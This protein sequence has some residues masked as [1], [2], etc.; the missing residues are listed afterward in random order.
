MDGCEEVRG[1]EGEE[2]TLAMS[3]CSVLFLAVLLDGSMFYYSSSSL[4]LRCKLFESPIV[5][6]AVAAAV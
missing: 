6:P 5:S 4:A 1:G 3:F 2:V